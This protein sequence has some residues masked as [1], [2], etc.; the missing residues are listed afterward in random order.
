MV[1]DGSIWQFTLGLIVASWETRE[2]LQT[3]GANIFI[4]THITGARI[5]YQNSVYKITFCSDQLQTTP[6][7]CICHWS[8]RESSNICNLRFDNLIGLADMCTFLPVNLSSALKRDCSG[9]AQA[10]FWFHLH[11]CQ[12]RATTLMPK[13][14]P[15]SCV[16]VAWA[17]VS[18]MSSMRKSCI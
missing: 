9:T 16:P 13:C 15:K 18:F 4:A 6:D 5:V 3:K 17:G 1:L 8:Y 14:E 11:P 10:R 7:D 12:C 2:T